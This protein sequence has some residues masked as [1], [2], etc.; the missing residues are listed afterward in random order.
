M[1]VE[2]YLSGARKLDTNSILKHQKSQ[3]DMKEEDRLRVLTKI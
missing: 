2:K 3:S 1:L